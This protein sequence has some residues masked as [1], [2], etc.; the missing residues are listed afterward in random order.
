M[1][2][3]NLLATP[4]QKPVTFR[5]LDLPPFLGITRKD[6][7]TSEDG[8]SFNLRNVMGLYFQIIGKA[9]KFQSGL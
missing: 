6:E 9:P 7:N 1:Q 5:M 8:C 3:W 2:F 4:A